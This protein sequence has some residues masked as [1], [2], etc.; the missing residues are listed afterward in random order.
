M[1]NQQN[2]PATL[3]PDAP[4]TIAFAVTASDVTVFPYPTRALY[5]GGTGDIVVTMAGTA[6]TFKSVPVGLLRIACTQV[7]AAGGA[8]T[9]TNI[10]GLN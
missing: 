3:P 1:A 6:I 7:K 9:A 2:P 10:L 8:T 4:F 5:V